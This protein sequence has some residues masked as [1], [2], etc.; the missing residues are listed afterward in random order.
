MD[1]DTSTGSSG[2]TSLITVPDTEFAAALFAVG[3][4]FLDFA[5]PC[6]YSEYKGKTSI[7]WNMQSKSEDGKISVASV[8]GAF[9]DREAWIKNNPDHAFGYALAAISNYVKMTELVE[10]LNP[11]VQFKLKNGARFF[12]E[13]G[14]EKYD[15][16]IAKGL[17][18]A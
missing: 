7:Q 12:V 11:T 5:S 3:V 2:K 6:K 16:L 17:K 9:K 8:A 14:S 15:K 10:K 18:P 1:S 4:P 13:K